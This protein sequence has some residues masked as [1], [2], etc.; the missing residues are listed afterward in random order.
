MPHECREL[1]VMKQGAESVI[2]MGN[3][4]G[5]KV[6]VK[7]RLPKRYR[8]PMLDSR[9]RGLRTKKE[10]TM[11][12]EVRAL[13]IDTPIVYDID[14][15]KGVIVME[16]IDGIRMKDLINDPKIS[17]EDKVNLCYRVGSAVGIM[18]ANGYI[19]GDLTTSNIIFIGKN[20][21]FIDFSLGFKSDKIEDMG[22]DLRAFEEAYLSTHPTFNS[23]WKAILD[24]YRSRNPIGMK[25]IAKLDEIKRRGRYVE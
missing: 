13:G 23:G 22:V 3:Y 16:Y 6:V 18:H 19:H 17:S 24:G 8:H 4:L 12:R 21:Y 7:W 9:L 1:K 15:E 10:V 5:K 14:L 20:P 25:A 2:Y 11:L